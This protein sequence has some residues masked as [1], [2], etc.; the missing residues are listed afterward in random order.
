MIFF[1]LLIGIGFQILSALLSRPKIE[2]AKPAGLDEFDIPSATEGRFIPVIVGKVKISGPNVLWYGDYR[3]DPITEKVGGFFGIGSKTVVIGHRYHLGLQVAICRGPIDGIHRVWYGDK[4]IKSSESSG[5]FSYNND[6]HFGGEKNGG[7]LR[8]TMNVRLGA[9]DQATMPYLSGKVSPLPRFQHTAY[10]VMQDSNQGA[11]IGDSPQLR[12]I[13]FEPFWYPNSLGVPDNKHRIG[14]DANPICFLYEILVGNSDWGLQL[15]GSDVLLTGTEAQGALIPVAERIYDEGLGFSMVISSERSARDIIDEIE[16]HVDGVFRLDNTDGRFK[17]ILARPETSGL[18]VLDESNVIALDNFV[19]GSLANTVN[20]VKL[21]YDDR[22]KNYDGTFAYA[23]DLGNRFTVGRRTSVT[24]KFAG[25][26]TASVANKIATREL[27]AESFPLSKMTCQVN[28]T[29]YDLQRGTPF[30]FDWPALGVS[31]LPM[32]V[33]TIDFGSPQNQGIT[34]TALEDIYRLED[35]GFV[36]PP[37]SQWTPP[38]LDAVAA[39]QQ[40]LWEL[41]YQLAINNGNYIASLVARNGG[42]HLGYDVITD[43]NGGTNYNE[44]AIEQPFTPIALLFGQ[45]LRDSG[46]VNPYET[47]IIVDT[48]ID[49]NVNT[50]AADA[51]VSVGS[52]IE[53]VVLVDDELMWFEQV[54][55]NGNGSYT[56]KCHRGAFDTIPADHA[57]NAVM[58]F[59]GTAAG[60]IYDQ[61]ITQTTALTAKAITYSSTG[62]L[63][64]GDASQMNIT[65]VNRADGPMPPADVQADG[66]LFVDDDDFVG[67]TDP[68][69]VTWKHR[70]KSQDFSVMQSSAGGTLEPGQTYTVIVRRTS[71]QVAID[72]TT[73]LTGTSHQLNGVI[74]AATPVQIEVYSVLNGINSQTWISPEFSL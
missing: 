3:A 25:V 9:T 66:V 49:V 55:D 22:S 57:D 21:S 6:T 13:A 47:D 17:I 16:R 8:F 40:L 71:D 34:V 48:L 4:K 39:L 30:L 32:R 28:R 67:L 38:T 20:E 24:K 46:D 37:A 68:I 14:N 41:P 1:N 11:Y 61:E 70:N 64:E 62:E 33:L 56:L 73:G 50:I 27:L 19:R 2:D 58:W 65:P 54:T 36:D 45:V 7:G 10:V 15:Q 18:P 60:L 23:Q 51:S 12:N 31:N 29:L 72:T 74:P 69:D 43:F 35:A 5:D 53:N 44:T 59:I 63:D 26:K 52:N 42:Q